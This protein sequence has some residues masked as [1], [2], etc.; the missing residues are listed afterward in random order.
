MSVQPS[1]TGDVPQCVRCTILG[2]SVV[3]TVV[4]S[5]AEANA[6]TGIRDVLVVDVGGSRYRIDA[7][8]AEAC[9]E[10]TSGGR[11]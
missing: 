2:T 3:G 10:N 5:G 4:D 9:P 6:A 1:T 11:R 7:A 8:D